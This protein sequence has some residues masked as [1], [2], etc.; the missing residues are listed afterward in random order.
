MQSIDLI[1]F[2]EH[3][4]RELDIACAVKYLTQTRAPISVEVRSIVLGL[5][6]TLAQFMPRVVVLPFCVSVKSLN[7]ERI[8]SRWPEAVYINLSYEQLLGQAQ[9][10]FKRP[11][12]DFARNHVI[13]HAWGDFFKAFLH[14]SGVPDTNIVVNG[15][16]SYALYLDPYKHYYGE[17]RRDLG[18]QYGLDTGKRWV[19]VPENYGWAFFENHMLRDR[20]KRGFDRDQA[21]AY[22]DFSVDS[23]RTATEWWCAGAE[24]RD[25]E[26]V[27]RPRPAVPREIF[28]EKMRLLTGDLSDQLHIIKAG[29]VREWILAS[30][31]VCSSYSTTL[32]EAATARKTVYMLAPYPFPPFIHVDWNDLADKVTTRDDFLK[33]ITR[34]V[35]DPNWQNLEAWVR[36]TMLGNPDPIANLAEI[37]MKML[38]GELHVPPPRHIAEDLNRPSLEKIIRSVRKFGWTAMQQTLYA[39]GIETLAQRWNPHETD[40]VEPQEVDRRVRAWGAVLG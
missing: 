12:D 7:L 21:Y 17:V 27:V 23:L 2:I 37:L 11:S 32:L 16:P 10:Q 25:I 31:I 19:F 1:Y 30:D 29:S 18:R 35:L 6:A 5:E 36:D 40:V 28:I 24:M 39:L 4:A 14:G 26:L 33:A 15:N 8:V 9:K 34:P 22:R 3:T 20:I 38:E 13:H